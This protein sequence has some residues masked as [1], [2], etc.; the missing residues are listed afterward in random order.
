MYVCRTEAHGSMSAHIVRPFTARS[1]YAIQAI[2]ATLR[3]R[4]YEA[5]RQAARK[6]QLLAH[7][8]KLRNSA[9]DLETAWPEGD[10]LSDFMKCA[11]NR[12]TPWTEYISHV[13]ELLVNI[14]AACPTGS[15]TA[16]LPSVHCILEELQ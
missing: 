3:A 8:D 11:V 2:R 12:P 9:R 4:S 16:L 10:P 13:C 1:V 14:S 6:L 15:A 7:P 5:F